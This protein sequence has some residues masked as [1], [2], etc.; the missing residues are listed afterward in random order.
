ME[1]IVVHPVAT[2]IKER[3][4]VRA[5]KE[6]P[7]SKELIAELLELSAWAPNH[8]LREPWR[9]IVFFDEG[10]EVLKQAIMQVPKPKPMPGGHPHK[11]GKRGPVPCQIV[12]VV[13]ESA[14]PKE[15]EEDY[16][17]TCALIQNFQLAA[18]EV[19]LG[20]T[21]VSASFIRANEFK[22]GIGVTED[23]KVVALLNV[24]YP[25]NVPAPLERQSIEQKLTI[26]DRALIQD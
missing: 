23:E 13:S 15:R 8:K 19:G 4:T 3:R 9:F 16:A 7:V 6:E 14:Q 20:V 24:G 22:E 12:V 25:E 11:H 21:W 18:W 26:I 17:A 1:N 5:F 2:A 10:R